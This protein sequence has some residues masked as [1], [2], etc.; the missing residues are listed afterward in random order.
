MADPERLTL[1]YL[2]SHPGDAARVLERMSAP[3]CAGLLA[4]VPARVGAPVIAAMLPTA[5][6][7]Q[8]AALDDAPAMAL[9]AALG[10]QAAVTILRHVAEPRRMRLLE[11]LPTATALAS[12]LLL[13]YREDAVGAWT[14]PEVT[15]LLPETR[16][17]EALERVRH[18]GAERVERIY[19]VDPEHKLLGMLELTTLL[20]APAGSRIA[21]LAARTAA[22]IAGNTPLAAAANHRGWGAS[23][24][25]VVVDRSGRLLGVLRREALM[26][27]LARGPAAQAALAEATVAG[28]LARG[29]WAAVSGLFAACLA[30]LPGVR[31]VGGAGDE[32]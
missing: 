6:A 24:T 32:R 22:P 12:R 17:E 21:D 20:R 8:L 7:R 23:P 13:D 5:A 18:G 1:S 28:S 31:P 25:M 14:D 27:A 11:G 10:P 26:R 16:V 9:L 4:R 2:D 30:V 19:M 15:A 3:E 29:Y